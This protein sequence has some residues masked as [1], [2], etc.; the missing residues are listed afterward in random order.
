MGLYGSRALVLVL[1]AL[2]LGAC[3]D[4]GDAADKGAPDA[5]RDAGPPKD[6]SPDK[7]APDSAASPDTAPV[8]DKGPVADALDPD[9]S[10][11]T[12]LTNENPCKTEKASIIPDAKEFGHLFAVRLTPKTYPFTVTNLRYTLSRGK[13]SCANVIAHRVEVYVSSKTTPDNSPTIKATINVPATT[14]MVGA[15]LVTLTLPTPIKLQTGEHIFV[16]VEMATD[17]TKKVIC[18]DVCDKNGT[19][20]R[21]YWSN[22]TKPPYKWATLASFGMKVNAMIEALGY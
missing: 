18:M 17:K 13:D 22:A 7:P 19:T 14:V 2:L 20:D 16:A 1:A 3:S 10:N 5:A 15:R 9:G 6:V 8:P 11:L 4:D 12:L 21:N